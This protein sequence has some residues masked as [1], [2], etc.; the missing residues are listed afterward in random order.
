[1]DQMFS[2]LEGLRVA[3]EIERRGFAFYKKAYEKFKDDQAKALFKALMEEEEEHLKIFTG[4][5][6][7]LEAKKEAH[8]IEYLFD[9]E[10]SRY[11]LVLA[12]L[13]VFPLESE[14]A[15]VIE[16]L[17]TVDKIIKLAMGA[18]KDSILLY[19]EMENNAKFD[20]S[21][22]VF[23]KLKQEEH[24]HVVELSGK[25]KELLLDRGLK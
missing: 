11:L 22:E 10:I 2:D 6:M 21:R 20:S 1:M 5:F 16:G 4:F 12:E 23:A 9:P 18:E 19:T 15:R 13:H 17:D 14:T 24:R 7:E 3:M 25:F 8:S